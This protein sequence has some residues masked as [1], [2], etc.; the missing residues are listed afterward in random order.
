MF[1]QFLSNFSG[2]EVSEEIFGRFDSELYKN[3]LMRC[4]NFLSLTQ[5]P[6][7]YRAGL[8]FVHPTRL[9][10]VARQER[11][12]FND[13]QVY[14]LEF[15]NAKLRIYEDAGLT[16]ITTAKVI[17][18]FTPATGVVDCTGHSYAT[19]DEIRITG[20]VGTTEL[21]DRFYRVVKIDNDSYTLKDL[22]G[23]VVDT[24]AYTAYVSDGTSTSVF[25]LTSPYLLADLFEFQFDQEGNTAYFVHRTYAP[26]KLV[27]VS[28]TSWTFATYSRTA[29]PFGSSDLFPGAV[30]FYEGCLYFASS[31]DFPDRL[32]RSRGPQASGA[33]RYDDFTT[34][35]DADHAI[36]TSEAIGKK[37]QWLIGLRN[38]LT[39]G[40][41]DGVSGMD[42]GQD[43]AITPTNFKIR[44]IDPVGVQG[45]M[46]VV[47]GQSIF[48]MQKGSRKLLSFDY[49]LVIDNYKSTDRQ[50]IASH[51]TA[52]GIKQLA[53]Q[54][55]KSNL[56]WAV[57]NDGV[58]ICLTI[59][60]KEDV[61]GWHRH[62]IGGT[63]VKVLSVSVEPQV[64]G[65]DRLYAV[66]ERTING[67][68]VRYNE[69][70][71]DPFEG[72]RFD[73][74]FTGQDNKA[75]DLVTYLAAVYT[76]QQDLVYLDGSLTYD[77][78]STSTIPGLW[79]LEGET[80][81][82]VGDGSKQAD[83]VVADGS[84]TLD[85]AAEVVHVGYKYTGIV[86]PLNLVV[87]G[88]VQNSISFGKNV[89]SIA[90]VVSN[91]IGVKY[92]TS[93]YNLQDIP[94][95]QI[96]QDTDAP[97]V[98]FTGVIP[99][100]NDDFWAEDKFIVYVQDDPYPAMLNAINVT[101][102]VGEK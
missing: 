101:I 90:L 74:Y 77:G 45:I 56:L 17:S 76:A 29:D 100:P 30:S 28:A 99:L 19:N 86:I 78:V 53:I 81:S 55:W 58:L 31:V 83:K 92:G 39:I 43:A 26:Y 82:I 37:I 9:Q 59:K 62:I 96:G 69:Y 72:I 60:P 61:S 22:Y 16:L 5:G 2:G 24:T 51:L 93:L 49:D 67:T 68:T 94:A 91:T 57:R 35:A 13:E 73:D 10:Q 3:A 23:N 11:F 80:V 46:P 48:Y 36:I 41:E 85:T 7:Q 65:Y 87:L 12:K 70:L 75:A 97:P 54:R 63:D 42:A 1:E 40:A 25:E 102:E 64:S 50:F 4:Q 79:H 98:P 47:D 66:V 27:R 89:S 38:F 8:T 84:I 20:V 21:N 6:A 18:G 15:T 32:W 95:S 33:T 88:Q 44:P 14:I 52:G 34:G 71:N